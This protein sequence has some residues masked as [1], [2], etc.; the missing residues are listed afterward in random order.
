MNTSPRM[1]IFKSVLIALILTLVPLPSWLAIIRPD[2]VVLTVLYW[3]IR[4]PR[5]GGI[6]LGWACGL[7]LDAFQGSVLGEHALAVA[8]VAYLGVR[9]HQRIRTKPLLQQ[10]LAVLVVLALYEF[11]LW[12]VDGWSGHPL[13][14]ALRW[15]PALTGALLWPVVAP[16]LAR[17]YRPRG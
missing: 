6:G 4:A 5:S 16:I 3:S 13:N 17:S 11:V 14:T 15:V 7:I 10:S 1:A 2:F 12:A 8:L 9:E